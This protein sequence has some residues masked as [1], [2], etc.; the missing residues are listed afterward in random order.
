MGDCEHVKVKLYV[1]N[2]C[3]LLQVG[4]D[5]FH[6]NFASEFTRTDAEKISLKIKMLHGNNV[7][8]V[9]TGPF[10]RNVSLF[11]KTRSVYCHNAEHL[12]YHHCFLYSFSARYI[13]LLILIPTA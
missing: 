12:F 8:Y 1:I 7:H 11:S 13:N 9:K 4:T 5:C 10:G 6:N 2:I 3:R